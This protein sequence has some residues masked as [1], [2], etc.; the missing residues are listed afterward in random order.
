MP[1]AV[2]QVPRLRVNADSN[3]ARQFKC[4][5]PIQMPHADSNAARPFKRRTAPFQ[6]PRAISCGRAAGA[7]GADSNRHAARQAPRLRVR[8]NDARRFK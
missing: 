7:A 2:R 1:R 4:R 8:A 6:V 5:T 3:D